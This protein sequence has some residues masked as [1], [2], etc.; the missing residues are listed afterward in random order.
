M[1]GRENGTSESRAS[2]APALQVIVLGSGGG[3]LENNTSSFLV[4]SLAAKW[5][6]GSLV[7][8]DAGV[9]LAPIYKILCETQPPDLA[10]L[11]MPHILQDGPFAGLEL[12]S[13]HAIKNAATINLDLLETF[14]ITHPHFDHI[15]A[16]VVNTSALPGGPRAKKVAGL[17]M[18]VEALKNHVFN[19]VLWPNLSDENQGAG[20]I[21][22]L[23]LVD[24][25]SPAMGQGHGKGYVEVA[26]HLCVKAAS[27]SHG[28]P[29]D[30]TRP[31]R[32]SHSSATGT[33]VRYASFDAS[34]MTPSHSHSQP[35]LHQ[36]HQ[37][38]HHGHNPHHHHHHALHNSHIASPRSIQ[39]P[40]PS[41]LPNHRASSF[42]LASFGNATTP[43]PAPPGTPGHPMPM[44]GEPQMPQAPVYDSTAYFL[45]DSK[46]GSEILM[47]GDVEPDRLSPFPRNRGIWEEAAPK[48]AR[49]DLRA[50][51]I[52]CSYDDSHPDDYMFGHLKPE[53]IADEMRTLA[54]LVDLCRNPLEAVQP[55]GRGDRDAR[56][57]TPTNTT[58]ATLLQ[59][60][61][62]KKRKR[63]NSGVPGQLLRRRTGDS[64]GEAVS[65]KTRRGRNDSAISGELDLAA[66]S[67]PPPSHTPH[68]ATPTAE[69]SLR[70]IEAQDLAPATPI[71]DLGAAVD[72]ILEDDVDAMRAPPL[73][74][75][76]VVIIHIKDTLD[77]TD[78]GARILGELR[79]HEAD[80]PTGVEFIISYPGQSIFV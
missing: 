14:L 1:V 54:E 76:R 65:P 35:Q 80:Q 36:Q 43:G 70:E 41:L 29:V 34:S 5:Q 26:L 11:P 38:H 28:A 15:S 22:Y 75:L 7:S 42:P 30:V 10:S 63:Q 47:F 33:P 24:G 39:Q 61:R 48:I 25:G 51:F 32:G 9:H 69:L 12:E 50:I 2:R 77:G 45:R 44:L 59:S 57:S 20:L 52:E 16:L 27:I 79:E 8:V 73:D 17:P 18:T 55:D 66:S 49:G 31:A 6:R 58:P 4:R 71:P 68:L 60:F 67:G 64:G 23:R 62:D 3:P 13:P 78:Q 72:S 46:T 37:Y 74:G 19:N 53:Y 56:A 40:S 21:T